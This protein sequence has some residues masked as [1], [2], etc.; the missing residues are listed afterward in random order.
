[1]ESNRVNKT[2]SNRY[3]KKRNT[4]LFFL[5]VPAFMIFP[6]LAVFFKLDTF[7]IDTLVTIYLPLVILYLIAVAMIQPRLIIY[8]MYYDY[9]MLVEE[10]HSPV[11][12]GAELFTTSWINDIKA[13]G[14]KVAQDYQSYILMYQHFKK[15]DKI[16]NSDETLVFIVVA[17]NSKTDFYSEELDH[18]IQSVYL[19]NTSFQK[20]SKQVTL[21]FKKFDILDEDS[22]EEIEKAIL[23]K[24]GKQRVVN[25]TIGYFDENQSIYSICPKKRYPNK[26]VFFACQEIKR[27]SYI[28]E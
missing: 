14:Y 7:A 18:N 23:F 1:M 28:K 6:S 20:I 3:R 8:S 22:K 15:L 24:S 13:K 11:K 25:F 5:I 21:Q 2:K 19:E 10:E 17:K 9:A 27:L 26:Y 4:L 12:T 16:V